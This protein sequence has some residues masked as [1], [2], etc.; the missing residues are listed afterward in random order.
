[1]RES[2]RCL[3]RD[4]IVW[5]TFYI[6]DKIPLREARWNFVTPYGLGYTAFPNNPDG[7]IAY[8]YE[9]VRN[10]IIDTGF[11]IKRYIKGYWRTKRT[12]LDCDEQDIFVLE[13]I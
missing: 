9:L 1:L 7:A 11:N 12:T 5:A 10:M 4:G 6:Y 2:F 3:K 13:K 8:D